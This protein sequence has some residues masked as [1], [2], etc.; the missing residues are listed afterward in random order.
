MPPVYRQVIHCVSAVLQTAK[1]TSRVAGKSL[2]GDLQILTLSYSGPTMKSD[3]HLYKFGPFRL[4]P[5]KRLLLRGGEPLPLRPKAFDTLPALAQNSGRVIGKV[6]WKS[7][8]KM[9]R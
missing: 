8:E 1:L 9:T 3:S 4:D 7:I 5:G 2:Q 6:E